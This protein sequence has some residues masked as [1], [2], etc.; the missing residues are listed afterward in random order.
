[1]SLRSVALVS[2]LFLAY[3]ISF[4]ATKVSSPTP[5]IYFEPNTG[6]S[7]APVKYL[8]RNSRWAMFLEERGAVLATRKGAL[9]LRFTGALKPQSIEGAEPQPGQTSYYRGADSRN[10]ITGVPHYGKVRYRAI[11]PGVDVLFYSQGERLEY[12]FEV[13]PGAD[14]S[15]IRMRFAAADSVRLDAHG[16]AIIES[17]AGRLVQ[18]KPRVYQGI[19]GKRVEL[20]TAYRMLDAETLG[21][22]LGEY[23]RSRSLTIDPVVAFSTMVG[24]PGTET[25]TGVALD[26]SGNIFLA[27][28]TTSIDYPGATRTANRTDTDVVVTKLDP[29]GRTNLGAVIVGGAYDEQVTG[30]VSDSS[31]AIYL[32]GT[33]NVPAGFPTTAGA[34]WR[35]PGNPDGD[36][37]VIKLNSSLGLVYSTLLHFGWTAGIAVDNSGV[38][39]TGTASSN[40]GFAPTSGAYA[41]KPSDGGTNAVGVIKLNAA[42]SAAV[43]A[44]YIGDGLSQ[45][46][47]IAVDSS[48]NAVVG[49]KAGFSFPMV[50]LYSAPGASFN[51]FLTRLDATGSRILSSAVFAAN[52]SGTQSVFVGADG[53]VYGA[54]EGSVTPTAGVLP[55]SSG[56]FLVKLTPSGA[57]NYS[58][59][60]PVVNCRVAADASGQVTLAGTFNTLPAAYPLP[61]TDAFRSTYAAAPNIYRPPAVYWISADA[62][63]LQYATYLGGHS[64]SFTPG[65]QL[66]GLVLDSAGNAYLSGSSDALDFAATD[67]ALQTG[68][69]GSSDAWVAKL[70]YQAGTPPSLHIGPGAITLSTYAGDPTPASQT[71]SVSS[72]G[73]ALKFRVATSRPDYY[74]LSASSY[75]TPA[76]VTITPRTP[77]TGGWGAVSAISIVAANANN[78]DGIVNVTTLSSSN[79]LFVS[80][81]ALTLY[82]AQVGA[83]PSAGQVIAT[84]RV[85][86]VRI[87]ANVTAGSSWLVVKANSGV[88]PA[89]FTV[90]ANTASVTAGT[91]TG[92]FTIS[93]PDVPGQSAT[94]TVTV[95]LAVGKSP[96][97]VSGITTFNPLSGP[98]GP[99][100]RSF[101]VTSPGP[102]IPFTIDTSK[103]P[104]VT[105]NP[106]SGVTPATVT[107]TLDTSKTN[108]NYNGYV[109]F[110]APASSNGSVNVYLSSTGCIAQQTP[111]V[112][113]PAAGGTRAL[114]IRGQIPGN[115][116]PALSVVEPNPSGNLTAP[117]WVTVTRQQVDVNTTV[118]QFIFAPNTGVKRQ[119]YESTH[120]ISIR[121]ASAS[122]SSPEIVAVDPYAGVGSYATFT[123][124]FQHP[125]GYAQI[126]H[127]GLLL[128]AT[129]RTLQNACYVLYDVQADSLMLRNDGDTAWL[130]A[131]PGVGVPIA[132]SHC[133]LDP[134]ASRVEPG[135]VYSQ[136]GTDTFLTVTVALSFAPSF[137]LKQN[138]FAEV[139]DAAGNQSGWLPV[140]QWLPYI[141]APALVNWYRLYDPTS[142][143]HHYTTDP[144]E[145]TVLGGAGFAQ[146]GVAGRVYNAPATNGGVSAT[147]LY[148]IYVG[149]GRSHFWT[150]DRNEY[151]TLIKSYP[152][153]YFGEGIDG[154]TLPSSVTGSATLYRL[155]HCCASP[156][157]HHWTT[158]SHEYSVLP[159]SG[160][161]QEGVA[162]YLMK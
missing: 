151:M 91:Y 92:S 74:T 16:D 145:Y 17:A 93:E 73:G 98:A 34:F 68:P 31:G 89:V 146:E 120:G 113:M 128:N 54:G 42:G 82:A 81:N 29:T 19:E 160:W 108:V 109:V 136:S 94:A 143:S 63:R 37:F 14:V 118:L 41:T 59:R 32:T 83:T 147:A 24:G 159:E 71:V 44:T 78:G 126:A 111:W 144:Y 27:G 65:E 76:T 58:L 132:N 10:W 97:M 75:T 129:S 101:Q 13:A 119:A 1:M 86:P 96:L 21:V 105:V 28:T 57:L 30:V 39:L 121:Q 52:S 77:S 45:G 100:S 112:G 153:V 99:V 72:I 4:A 15:V 49:G 148:R 3:S 60:L 20:T 35:T 23:D 69:A 33:A 122:A 5:E 135:S 90:S 53:S 133:T 25:N 87:A 139:D 47:S 115:V 36:S 125:Q 138:L 154:F 110:S 50:G 85:G 70:N 156:P 79:S 80:A 106:S 107:V 123:A 64:E 141:P 46:L 84:N 43:Y 134:V 162:A 116:C 137:A 11:Y 95:T 102:S 56:G 67:G 158:D 149:P 124:V 66:N 161:I 157:I 26:S 140:G 7:T 40:R 131:T 6:Q 61:T 51:A 9:Q 152:G 130:T 62:S 150:T 114:T 142:R 88:T 18:K 117:N 127:A 103:S 48:G 38:Y 12:D 155:V 55:A 104:Y 22:T 2:A 8:T